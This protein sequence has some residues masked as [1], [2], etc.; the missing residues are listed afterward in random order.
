MISLLYNSDFRDGRVPHEPIDHLDDFMLGKILALITPDIRLQK[1]A[2][3]VLERPLTDPAQ[4]E[5]RREI[6]RD[7]SARRLPVERLAELF[8]RF[9]D[10]QAGYREE[11][12]GQFRLFGGRAYPS[13]LTKSAAGAVG[14]LIELIND[15]YEIFRDRF[16]RSVGLNALK[17]RISWL[18]ESHETKRLYILAV[19]F[20]DFSAAENLTVTE[21]SVD[22]SGRI[23]GLGIIS[24]QR[25]PREQK[26]VFGKKSASEGVRAPLFA[27]ESGGL[28]S[29]SAQGLCEAFEL[30]ISS[31]CGEFLQICYDLGFYA[32][33][34]RYC[35]ALKNI[36]VPAVY[37]D[38][39]GSTDIAG[40]YDLYLLLS[41]PNPETVVPNGFRLAGGEKGI[42]ITGKNSCG[43]TVYLRAATLALVFTAAGLPIPASAAKIS[44]PRE[45]LLQMASAE[46]AYHGGGIVGRFEEEVTDIKK[47]VVKASPGALIL[48]NEV[49]QTTDYTEGAEGLYYILEHLSDLG[50]KWVLVTHLKRLKELY[51]GDAGVIK[52]RED[53]EGKYKFITDPG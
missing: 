19:K 47:I 5:Y 12:S 22:E 21:F 38:L 36:G 37:A 50:A 7:F 8:G 29:A 43:K 23:S 32:F 33:A 48:L 44:L 6:I 49:F 42:I 27:E 9:G 53:G 13:E 25:M 52:L 40:L 46:R 51:G 11:K 41:T 2:R 17:E 31:L 1:A 39:G 14:K 45:I 18:C 4:V 24:T 30:A 34:V 26:R 3:E 16:P 20:Q 35:D 10:I 15:I 28:L